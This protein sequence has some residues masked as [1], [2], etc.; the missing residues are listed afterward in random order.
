[1][2][3]SVAA[4]EVVEEGRSLLDEYV[5]KGA[6]QMLRA[7]LDAEAEA[8]VER[9]ASVRDETGR[10]QVVRN[11]HLPE[12]SV[13]TGAG[14]LAVKQP[15]VRDRRGAASADAVRFESK[16]LPPYLRR[17]K[18]IDELIPWL[19]LRGVST[20]DMQPALEALVGE[21][22]KG[23]SAS[24][25]TRLTTRWRDEHQEWCKRD[26]AGKEYVYIWADGVVRHEAPLNRAG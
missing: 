22:A 15:R 4:S 9:H 6:R 19:Y 10:R 1:M 16:I 21:E 11:G 20:G 26:L 3:R 14:E 23:L 2:E 18:S 17:S 7:A 8:F 5:L 25:V 13:L 24:V 12:R